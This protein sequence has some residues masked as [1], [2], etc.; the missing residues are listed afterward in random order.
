M[1]GL[2]LCGSFIYSVD[3]G[4]CHT[5]H[6]A[7]FSSCKSRWCIPCSHKK[8]L[9]WLAKLMPVLEKWQ[10]RVGMLNFTIETG[11]DLEKQLKK[12][13]EGWKKFMKDKRV[14]KKFRDRLPGGL[15]SLEVKIAQGDSTHWHAH[16]HC[17]I[18]Q[19]AG[20]EK[21]YDW[22]KEKWHSA[23]GGSVWIKD[24]TKQK[25]KGSVEVLKYLIK[26]EM[27]LYKNTEMLGKAVMSLK[28]K[29]QINTW[30]LLRGLS[31]EVEDLENTWEE[32]KLTT[33]VCSKCGC[34]EGELLKMLYSDSLDY[35]LKNLK[36][37]Y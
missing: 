2:K 22:I 33:F 36:G 4:H 16:L 25:L 28:G 34:T 29:R 31:K 30:G 14:V 23:T 1:E 27:G 20:Y 11:P 9:A 6:F 8:T 10:G 17:L 7:G 37:K 35:D 12:L 18:L 26:P 24:I 32:K 21:D 19:P 5:K 15:R 13:Q 3:C